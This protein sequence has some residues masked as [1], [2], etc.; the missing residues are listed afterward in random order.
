MKSFYVVEVIVFTWK[1]KNE[2]LFSFF[3]ETMQHLLWKHL[4]PLTSM[5]AQAFSV[6][7]ARA[8]DI[9]AM[10]SERETTL[11]NAAFT[12]VK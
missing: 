5:C 2:W 6:F 1:I 9:K 11:L 4:S 12:L 10:E 3:N 7:R 8:E